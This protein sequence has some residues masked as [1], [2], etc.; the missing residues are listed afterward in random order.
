MQD[1]GSTVDPVLSTLIDQVERGN[2][3]PGFRVTLTLH[4]HVIS[5]EIVTEKRYRQMLANLA[6]GQACE[7]LP[8]VTNPEE[9]RKRDELRVAVDRIL[10]ED[11]VAHLHVLTD[12]GWERV[13]LDQIE[14]FGSSLTPAGKNAS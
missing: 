9:V 4:A 3:C 12:D 2:V 11:P 14:A 10:P 8:V 5:G 7:G 13:R 1:M 6:F